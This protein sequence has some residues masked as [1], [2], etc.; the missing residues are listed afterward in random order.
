MSFI[1]LITIITP[2]WNTPE[3]LMAFLESVKLQSYPAHKI[4]IIIIDNG[5]NDN[6]IL[7][8]SEW[9][10]ANPTFFRTE[11]ISFEK[12]YGIAAAYNIGFDKSSTESQIIIRT[13]S[14]VELETDC[15]K[16]LVVTLIENNSI[17]LVGARGVL[18]SNRNKMDH[19]ARFMNW[20]TG[21]LTEIDPK[22]LVECDCVFGGTFAVRKNLIQIIGYFFKSDRFLANELEFCTRVKLAG[23]K[24][25]CQPNAVSYHKVGNTTGKMNRKKFS[26][27]DARE[28][29]LFHLQ[30]NKSLNK[31]T[32]VSFFVLGS[33]KKLFS[34]NIYPLKG[35]I[36]A[37]FSYVLNKNVLLPWRKV[38]IN[39]SEWL[40][41]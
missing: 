12:N 17:G 13:E 14:D 15:I 9:F 5:S 26:F 21:T 33:I 18:Y 27:I 29:T 36:S 32:T 20:R 4:E 8:I 34:N 2:N 39:I 1:P 40:S 31:L 6:S 7:K 16:N 37:V 24:V 25:V 28:S 11:L 23:M 35:F 19:A 41:K 10:N 38:D 30:Y 3:L 22:E